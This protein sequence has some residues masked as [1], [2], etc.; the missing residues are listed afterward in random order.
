MLPAPRRTSLSSSPSPFSCML[1]SSS[2]CLSNPDPNRTQ[3]K[4]QQLHPL[5]SYATGKS[6]S[7]QAGRDHQY[8]IILFLHP[9]HGSIKHESNRYRHCKAYHTKFQKHFLISFPFIIIHANSQLPRKWSPHQTMGSTHLY[10][11]IKQHQ[12][13]HTPL[14]K[15]FLI[16]APNPTDYNAKFGAPPI[17]LHFWM[18]LPA[19]NSSIHTMHAMIST[20]AA[21]LEVSTIFIAQAHLVTVASIHHKAPP[22]PEQCHT[23]Y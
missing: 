22:Q 15:H 21:T 3:Q 9:K 13:I 18:P 11:S 8:P 14:L 20:M 19:N 6:T 5:V 12:D 1:R 16:F 23:N 10:S 17:R 4:L 7:F 2:M